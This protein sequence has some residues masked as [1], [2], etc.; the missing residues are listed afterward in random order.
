MHR[1]SL[2]IA[3]IFLLSANSSFAT[4]YFIHTTN[5]PTG[6]PGTGVSTCLA[7]DANDLSTLL[8]TDIPADGGTGHTVTVCNNLTENANLNLNDASHVGITIQ[9]DTDAVTVTKTNMGRDVIRMRGADQTIQNITLFGGSNGIQVFDVA[10]DAQIINVDISGTENDPILVQAPGALIQDVNIIGNALSNEG[11]QS[12]ATGTDIEII[13]TTISDTERDGIIIT[14]GPAT[15]TRVTIT[16]AGEHGLQ[17]SN[18]ADNVTITDIA[19]DGAGVNGALTN[20]DCISATGDNLILTESLPGNNLLQ[21]CDVRGFDL[22]IN[23]TG[24]ATIDGITV[25]DTLSTGAFF[26]NFTGG[27]ITNVSVSQ[28]NTAATSGVSMDFRD[29][30]GTAIS[31]LSADDSFSHGIHIRGGD[32]STY[33]GIN[34]ISDAAQSG[35]QISD[36]ADSNILTGFTINGG[37]NG[38]DVLLGV[39]NS[40]TNFDLSGG[41]GHGVLLGVTSVTGHS[42][43]DLTIDNF[44]LDCFETLATN[45]TLTTALLTNCDERGFNLNVAGTATVTDLTVT[46]TID[47]G[48]FLSNLTS[49]TFSDLTVTSSSAVAIYIENSSGITLEDMTIDG[50]NAGSGGLSL[51]NVDNSFFQ[52]SSLLANSITN[53]GDAANEHGLRVATNSD[54]NDFD[55]FSIDGVFDSG[56]FLASSQ[57]NTFD[58]FTIDTS[59]DDGLSLSTGSNGNFFTDFS[60]IDTND[61]GVYVSASMN[62]NFSNLDLTNPTGPSNDGIATTLT[63]TGNSFTDVN[64]DNVTE[65]CVHIQSDDSSL[66]TAVLTNCLDEGVVID[67]SGGTALTLD[68][69]SVS[70]PGT[71]GISIDDISAGTVSVTDISVTGATTGI[72][73]TTVSGGT[74]DD[75]DIQTSTTGLQ[76][77]NS[78]SN[79]FGQVGTVLLD[80]N[81]I[82]LSLITG[83]DF[84]NFDNLSVTNN[85]VDG[86]VINASLNNT[87]DNSDFSD[88]SGD[89]V[90]L[91]G[92]A[93]L[94]VFTENTFTDNNNQGAELLLGNSNSFISNE[95]VSNSGSGLE[96]SGTSASNIIDSNLFFENTVNGANFSGTGA[97]SFYENCLRN[98]TNIIDTT[99][100]TTY[101][102]AGS[103][104]FWGSIPAGTGFSETCTDA[105]STTTVQT[106]DDICDA[107]YVD[108]GT[109]DA[110]P[111]QTCDDFF[112]THDMILSK[113]ALTFNDPINGLESG[114]NNPKAI[115]GATIMYTVTAT[116]QASTNLIGTAKDA[117]ITDDFDAEITGGI[118]SWNSN[119]VISSPD[120][121]TSVSLDD[122]D[123][124]DA[125]EFISN[126]MTAQCGDLNASESCTLTFTLE[127]Q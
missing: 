89:G 94:N 53:I 9:G 69:I 45:T 124:S 93:N 73:L 13:D 24:T 97:N 62:N 118:L 66:T 39:S 107:A 60:I 16:N 48:I 98:S 3:V 57:N 111:L 99:A 88:N 40:F 113:T 92:T 42:F 120:A 126:I 100:S 105:G 91:E 31:N 10:T 80:T 78:D 15:L 51:S 34:T 4:N 74:F 14:T 8:L 108:G 30:S 18:G 26:R 115:P 103:G 58:T 55:D 32:A 29:V 59:S 84:N 63:A 19:V 122:P 35:L 1:R 41:S 102:N 119:M 79:N 54:G 82:G 87:F 96:V 21:N 127:V 112:T 5:T 90:R 95:F 71:L 44:S 50:G 7:P 68:D 38:I 6:A 37:T 65:Q 43:N 11:I 77:T 70:S 72:L 125:G 56:L 67:L 20:G 12:S 104:N 52:V 83:S 61:D 22:N 47:D 81:G 2:Y 123:D 36:N 114:G 49:G 64:I 85:T 116:N 101:V 86:A 25:R 75:L 110:L 28:P 117:T 109:T 33:S 17:L 106:D 76:L 23:G 121:G 46:N 27:S